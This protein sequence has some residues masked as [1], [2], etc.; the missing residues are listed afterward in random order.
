MEGRAEMNSGAYL[1][2]I[3]LRGRE[4]TADAE[5]LRVL[6]RSHL[7][8]VPFENLD[9]HWKR[10]ITV[11]TAKFYDKIVGEKRGGFCYELNGLFNELLRSLGFQTRLVSARVFNGTEYGPEYDH[12]AIIVTIGELEYL[13]DVGFGDFSAE[14]LRFLP[15]LEQQDREGTF[16]IKRAD[17]G[18]FD[19]SKKKGEEFVPQYVFNSFGRDLSEFAEMCDFQQYSPES[20]FTKGKV[21][22]ILTETGRKTLT[23]KAFIVTTHGERIESAVGSEDEFERIL[24]SE[25]GIAR[26]EAR[27]TST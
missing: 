4:I 5:S 21:C 2:R 9:I 3:G 10:P 7:F 23:D 8:T 17:P 6:Q 22:S 13:A 11:D 24:V 19:V 18:Y 16:V 15:D 20:H 12:A 14:P 27:V 25:F 26:T 1:E